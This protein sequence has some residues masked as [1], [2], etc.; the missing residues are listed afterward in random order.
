MNVILSQLLHDQATERP[1]GAYKTRLLANVE[2]VQGE[3]VLLGYEL[4][5]GTDEKVIA[6]A[7]QAIEMLHAAVACLNTGEDEAVAWQALHQAEIIL[8]N[9]NT[10]AENKIKVLSITNR[11]LMLMARATAL[12]NDEQV[13]YW[14]ATECAL[15]P[16]HVGMVLA[17]ADC[18]A[19]DVVTPQTLVFG[20]KLLAGE[21]Q[22]FQ[23]L[24][25][26]LKTLLN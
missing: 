18:H 2:R 4:C 14:R 12:P 16:L 6:R 25:K 11:T 3:L 17:G 24:A 19:T 7:A 10:D 22:T 5:G 15:N 13:M 23:S 20:E 21:T 26:N 9:L 8:A 1:D